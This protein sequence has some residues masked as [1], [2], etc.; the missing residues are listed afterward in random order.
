MLLGF[1]RGI[2]NQKSECP[3]WAHDFDCMIG[4]SGEDRKPALVA[5]EYRK[6]F[7]PHEC[8]LPKWDAEGFEKCVAPRH[9]PLSAAYLTLSTN[10]ASRG[11]LQLDCCCSATANLMLIQSAC[12]SMLLASSKG[13]C[14]LRC[15]EYAYGCGDSMSWLKVDVMIR[16]RPYMSLDCI[17]IKLSESWLTLR[18]KRF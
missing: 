1:Y 16:C 9:P 2:Y 17:C 3:A 13:A 7:R 12:L 15:Q 18:C 10:A 11:G 4:E 8:D 5:Q 6:V 14:C